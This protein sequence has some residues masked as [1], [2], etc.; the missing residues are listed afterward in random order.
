MLHLSALAAE[1]NIDMDVLRAFKMLNKTTPQ[2]AS[3]NPSSKWDVEDYYYAGGTARVMQNLS[4]KL[5]L[6]VMT[7]NGCTLGEALPKAKFYYDENPEVITTLDKPFSP[8]GGIAVLEGN[9]APHTGISKPVAIAPEMH[10]FVGKA[11]CFDSEERCMPVMWWSSATKA[12]R[13]APACARC[14]SL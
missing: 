3:V 9:L 10:H 5:N 13:A 14:A 6:D 1:A 4:S 11:I 8:T 2:L 12:P 7:V